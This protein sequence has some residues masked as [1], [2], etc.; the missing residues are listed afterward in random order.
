MK[1][2][3]T[4][5]QFKKIILNE[6]QPPISYPCMSGFAKSLSKFKGL[7]KQMGIPSTKTT[8]DT[9]DNSIV[10]KEID[11]IISNTKIKKIGMGFIFKSPSEYP[12]QHNIRRGWKL[13]SDYIDKFFTYKSGN[14]NNNILSMRFMIPY[15]FGG[16]LRTFVKN[17]SI[18]DYLSVSFISN[19]TENCSAFLDCD[20][21]IIKVDLNKKGGCAKPDLANMIIDGVVIDL[22]ISKEYLELKPF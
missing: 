11:K 9:E 1:I 12:K 16:T 2:R 19:G 5:R 17:A 13:Y 6:G 4:E 15:G 21:V 20:D 18:P 14:I 22:G 7:K 8:D 3:L 10:S